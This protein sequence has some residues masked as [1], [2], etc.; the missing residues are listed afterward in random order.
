MEESGEKELKDKPST[1]QP[2]STNL[3]N[4][5]IGGDTSKTV[6]ISLIVTVV[7]LSL[8]LF[9]GGMGFVTKKDFTAD[10]AGVAT[11]MEQAKVDLATAKSEVAIAV[12]G[13]PTIIANQLDSIVTQDPNQWSNQIASLLSKTD[14]FGEN[15]QTL[16]SEME[17]AN[18][19]IIDLADQVASLEVAVTDY[20]ERIEELEDRTPGSGTSS[21]EDTTI[22]TL[23]AFTN[24][25]SIVVDTNSYPYRIEEEG[26]YG[27]TLD[28]FNNTDTTIENV[29]TTITFTPRRNDR[30]TVD[31]RNVY[32]YSYGSSIRWTCRQITFT[33]ERFDLLSTDL[34]MEMDFTLEY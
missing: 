28:L 26:D 17:S 16:E 7:V 22:W 19:E 25:S 10:M 15:I 8:V 34:S 11:F 1:R 12:E 2:R 23:S 4:L 18:L 3:P 21:E 5:N 29:I 27:I 6:I 24:K 31:E 14:S 20:E 32:L 9:T 30:I 33:S 13:I